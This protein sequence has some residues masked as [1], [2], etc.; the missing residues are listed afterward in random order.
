[1]AGCYTAKTI[2]SH[3]FAKVAANNNFWINDISSKDGPHSPPYTLKNSM[4]HPFLHFIFLLP[5]TRDTFNHNFN[6]KRFHNNYNVH[7]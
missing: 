4:T 1:M 6:R 5:Y 3:S 2:T 7:L